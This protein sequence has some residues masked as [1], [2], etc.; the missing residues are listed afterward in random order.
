ALDLYFEISPD[1]ISTEAQLGETLLMNTRTLAYFGL[2]PLGSKFWLEMQTT[3]DADEV[4]RR[5]AETTGRSPSEL[6]QV[7]QS[8]LAGM[9][10]ARLLGIVKK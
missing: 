4:I 5:I 8:I 1:V 10:R 2:D 3:R 6:E 7:M 9:E